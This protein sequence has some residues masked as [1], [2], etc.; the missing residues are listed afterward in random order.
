MFVSAEQYL[1]FF[2]AVGVVSLWSGLVVALRVPK[3]E[4][5]LKEIRDELRER[6]NL[7][8]GASS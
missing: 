4:S 8:K 3:I 6:R 7:A 5:V 1:W 2:M